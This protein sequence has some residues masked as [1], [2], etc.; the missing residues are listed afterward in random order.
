LK[1]DATR[2]RL[3]LTAT[4]MIIGGLWSASAHADFEAS[5]YVE[6]ELRYFP[7][8]ASEPKQNQVN[9]SIAAEV[10]FEWVW[11]R[12]DTQVIFTPF[13][14]LDWR[15]PK[16]THWDVREAKFLHVDGD[17]ELRLGVDKV[18]WGVTEAVHVIDIVN[19]TDTIENVDGEDKLGQ[20]MASLA[21][22]T[23]I[24]VFEAFVLPYSRER[25][26]A[27]RGGR[28][29]PDFNIDADNPIF[30]SEAENW[31][32]DYA[33]RWSHYIGAWDFGVSHFGGTG[34]DPLFVPALKNGVEPVLR[35]FYPQIQQTSVDIQATIDALLYKF[36]GFT[37]NEL[38]ERYYQ[39]SGGI[40]YSFY[41]VFGTPADIGIV[42]EYIY[43]SRGRTMATTP[44]ANDAFIGLRWSGNDT[45]STAVL[46][47]SL[48]DVETGAMSIGVEA[49]TRLGQNYF[50]SV[51]TRWFAN[52]PDDDILATTADD[53]FVQ[54]R[55]QRFF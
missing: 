28:P 22:S 40:E 20:P 36:E 11:N 12:N 54:V 1:A 29:R 17:F 52:V 6:P 10:D 5:G 43:D 44:F 53:G 2:S 47:G 34:R 4:A 35:P 23:D 24:G 55:M 13:A 14:R 49:E 27:G 33:F 30:E 9:L 21:Y 8:N 50:I 41:G 31:H 45:Q 46:A 3:A 26:F 15:D 32:T 25:P 42:A 18:F 19:Q 51:E 48:V 16:R 37:R 38:G 7:E 39:A